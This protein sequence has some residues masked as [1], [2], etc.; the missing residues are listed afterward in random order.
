MTVYK[1][2]L[3]LCR[4]HLLKLA[5][6]CLPCSLSQ[7]PGL[8]V[9]PPVLHP[10]IQPSATHSIKRQARSFIRQVSVWSGNVLCESVDGYW[11]VLFA[12]FWN[13]WPV[14]IHTKRRWSLSRS[15]IYYIWSAA[16]LH[17]AAAFR[18][19]KVLSDGCLSQFFFVLAVLSYWANVPSPGRTRLHWNEMA[20]SCL[21]YSICI[22]PSNLSDTGTNVQM[23]RIETSWLLL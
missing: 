12:Y 16:T 17:L 15:N 9:P 23:H 20:N 21:S 5:F 2:T 10:S 14:K 11:M 3:R 4:Y 19:H 8:M 6:H 13:Y 22:Q 7:T 18:Y 1:L